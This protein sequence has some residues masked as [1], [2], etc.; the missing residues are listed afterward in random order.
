[1]QEIH[2]RTDRQRARA[3]VPAHCMTIKLVSSSRA[4]VSPSVLR[5]V[6]TI[7]MGF[8]RHCQLSVSV[9]VCLLVSLLA[10]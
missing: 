4:L 7:L 6:I 9:S 8:S 5:L 1:M 10:G 3:S 2:G